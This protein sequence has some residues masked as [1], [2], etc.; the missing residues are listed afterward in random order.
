M[1]GDS[2]PAAIENAFAGIP[3]MFR[4][5]VAKA[6]G[7]DLAF[8]G[9]PFDLSTST[10]PGA[11]YGP[12]GLRAAS[13]ELWWG[14]PV[15]PWGFNPFE[16]LRAV[17]CGDV[18]FCYGS[19]DAFMAEAERR[20]GQ[21]ADAGAL[22]VSLG[23]DHLTTL[24]ALR[25]LAR[26]HGSLG[27]VH[28]D[29]HADTRKSTHLTHGSVFH[30][31]IAEG[32]IDPARG[33][34]VGIR[35]NHETDTGLTVLT[36]PEVLDLG[37]GAAAALEERVARIATGPTYVSVD[38]DCLDPAH[39]PGTGTPVPGGLTSALL[40]AMLRRLPAVDIVACD[41]VEVA[42][43]LD[44][45]GRTALAGAAAI[46]ELVCAVAARRGAGSNA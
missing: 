39:A 44:P 36:A 37:P 43:D 5:P 16:R 21:I 41:L 34:Q 32:L 8:L 25:A 17:D 14:D 7:A 28:F 31:A 27:L 30:H 10:R 3:T 15:W 24:P 22:P 12:R 40:I 18:D 4:Q 46:L 26:R 35:T 1:T 42:P 9:L 33:L 20:V 45:T 38:I 29:A 11:R 13:L 23:G 19:T 2:A 6:D